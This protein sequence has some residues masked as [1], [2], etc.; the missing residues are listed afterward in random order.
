MPRSS[1]ALAA[2]ASAAVPGL[3][4][5]GTA[6]PRRTTPDFEV[7]GAIDST[8]RRWV[9]RCPR[10]DAAGAAVEAELPILRNLAAAVDDGRLPFAVPRPAGLVALPENGRAVVWEF[11]PGQDLRLDEL[12]GGPGLSAELGRAIAAVHEL[13]PRLVE[14]AGLPVYDAESYRRRCLAE[15]DEAARTGHVPSVL[16]NR[17]ERALEDVALWRFRAV[18]V[19]GDLAPENVLVADGTVTAM[20]EFT[21]MHVGDP[22]EDLAWLLASA[23]LEALD[24][25]AEAYDLAR[26]HSPDA[27]LM[28]RATLVSELAV[29]RWLLHG[30]RLEDQPVVDDAVRMLD[31]LADQ[32]AGEPPI[33]HRE[34]VVVPGWTAQ[35]DAAA[36]E[37]AD[38][39][40]QP[41]T[42]PAA[43][44]TADLPDDL[45]DP[46]SR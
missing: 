14:D 16:L 12:T 27:A 7:G 46:P 21:S 6:G 28:D 5:V 4:V 42:E 23:P 43:D 45:R 17:W 34:P 3:E 32:V 20:L 15:V 37:N 40:P 25:I 22:A 10:N 36:D 29:A 13:D 24:S 19:H 39:A 44:P 11:I 33:G 35:H 41:E 2:L 26:T 8:G 1:L 18:P 9:V 38:D 30:T 31:E